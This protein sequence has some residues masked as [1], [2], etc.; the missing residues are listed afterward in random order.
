MSICDSC[1]A[2]A[3]DNNCFDCPEFK[4]VS[5]GEKEM[6]KRNTVISGV[7]R[8]QAKV[9]KLKRDLKRKDISLLGLKKIA[10]QIE[11][12]ELSK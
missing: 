6:L 4:L 10:L 11:A 2:I 3:T 8:G 12:L 9:N 1:A 7:L 5:K